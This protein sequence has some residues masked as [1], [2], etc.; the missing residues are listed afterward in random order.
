MIQIL[1]LRKWLPRG[2]SDEKT[3]DAFHDKEWRPKSVK[4][5]FDNLERY[6][7][8]IP[9]KEHW[10]LFYT[11]NNCTEQ[12]RDFYSAE[13]FAF[14]IDGG[15][16]TKTG[17]DKGQVDLQRWE[18]YAAAVASVLKCEPEKLAVVNSGNGLHF[19][20][21]L[22]GPPIKDRDFF[23]KNKHHYAAVCKK[24]TAKLREK[25]LGG[26][27]DPSIF[28]H[29]RILRLPGTVNRK[30]NKPEKN[31]LL[32]RA[33][34]HRIKFDLKEL[35]GLPEVDIAQQI[36]KDIMAKYPKVDDKAIKEGCEFLKWVGKNGND[37]SEPLWY[38]ALSIAGRMEGGNEYAHEL[39]RGYHGYSAEET[40]Q[41]LEQAVAASGPRT[42][43]NIRNLGYGGC[44][45][46]KHFGEVVSPISI[47]SDGHI[48]TAHT[49]FHMYVPGKGLKPSYDDLRAY[50]EQQK[51][52]KG[53]DGSRSVFKYDKT[54]YTEITHN[55]I[56]NFAQDNF[57]PSAKTVMTKEFLNLVVRTNLRESDFWTDCVERRINFQNGFLDIETS[58]FSKHTPD[59]GF[60]Y[61][62]PYE[63]S[64]KAQAPVFEEMLDKITEGDG[65][66]KKVLLEYMGY[67]L[68]NDDCWT[69]K[70]AVLV[71]DGANGKSTFLGVLKALAG[72]D[73]YSSATIKDLQKSEYTRYLL[74]GKLFNVSE[75]TPN[76]ALM[77]T[78]LFKD[79]VTGGEIQVRQIYKD[80]YFMRN[81][82]KLIYSCNELSATTDTTNGYFR[83]L[84]L[85]PFNAK[86]D[87]G[88]KDYDPHIDKKLKKE[89][90]GIFNLALDGYK[91]LVLNG[92]FT[93]A[94]R[95]SDTIDLYKNE[96]DTVLSWF[97]ENMHVN[98]D[99][100][101]F[102][103]I[104]DIY[105]NY[106][107]LT[108]ARGVRP[109][110]QAKFIRDLRKH[111]P[112]YGTR[113]A[114]KRMADTKVMKRGLT[115]VEYGEGM[116]LQ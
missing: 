47:V 28:D 106:K 58:E 44:R 46:C 69:Q 65:D 103:A 61:V 8:A 1:G 96:T 98:G 18:D 105:T 20:F 7:A 85:I 24:I 30:P 113:E 55:H 59:I 73:N 3:F 23:K 29:R 17:N 39:S 64:A 94:R 111:I 50:F 35:S 25:G 52:Y 75:E 66:T 33:T 91:R 38:A 112:D 32:L 76:S 14:D 114:R 80:S 51:N 26:E 77:D 93:E 109:V 67:C 48:K 21:T 16:D 19:I 42:C 99:D 110:T 100:S 57:K 86:F 9:E 27:P 10:N 6:L 72:Q 82:A 2:D 62:L 95:V 104:S 34:V 101:K 81:R 71:G 11:L 12:K 115:G 31:A 36:P 53:F 97:S 13:A 15:K 60:R 107:I 74:D 43:E 116:G 22:H 37:V 4:E 70:A 83:R 49:G 45:N 78:S 68:S 92:K 87:V 90:S 88:G 54:H 102:A 79:L 89:L 63:Y 56:E 5:L 108:E 41:K 84:V 40:D